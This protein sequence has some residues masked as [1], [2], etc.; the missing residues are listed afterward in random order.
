LQNVIQPEPPPELAP[1]MYRT[2][3]T[4]L[5]SAHPVWIHH[6]VVVVGCGLTRGTARPTIAPTVNMIDE[7]LETVAVDQIILPTESLLKLT[8]SL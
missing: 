2:G 1:N 8:R 5:L 7:M 6:N 4:M 3:L